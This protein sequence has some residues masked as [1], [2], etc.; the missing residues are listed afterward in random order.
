MD[1]CIVCNSPDVKIDRSED[2]RNIL[3]VNCSHC[4]QYKTTHR[5]AISGIQSKYPPHVRAGIIRKI[6]EFNNQVE[7]KR[8]NFD[9]LGS[10]VFIPKD[11][12]E[13]MDILIWHI[14]QHTGKGGQSVELI[15]THDYPI[16][17]S[18]DAPEFT[19]IL[20]N[21][22]NEGY[23]E[24]VSGN[25]HRLTAKGWGYINDLKKHRISTNQA[26]VAMWFDD[27]MK[28]VYED[29]I[30]PALEELD[31]NPIRIDM[32]PHN[33]DIN[34]R[35]I[36]EIRKSSLMVADF[37]GQRNGVYFEA[38]FAMGLGIPIIRTCRSDEIEDLHFDTEH[39]FH[40]EWENPEELY[41]KLKTH[42]EAT[43][44]GAATAEA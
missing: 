22:I 4:G 14:Y 30:E 3:Y 16:T 27:E 2:F 44:P 38:G 10:N 18:Q 40:I 42:I 35:I 19:F 34:D 33:E 39:Y 37:T 36:A 41:D 11:P 8:D 17:Y 15:S 20:Q 13:A 9:R 7:I 26:F 24:H 32:V 5:V 1:N 29:G 43:I 12:I 21:S 6:N 23:V 28:P 31:Y 25:G